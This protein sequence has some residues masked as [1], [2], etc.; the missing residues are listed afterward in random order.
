MDVPGARHRMAR[1]ARRPA[2]G[3]TGRT[4]A[5]WR[6]APAVIA[7]DPVRDVVVVVHV[8]AGA[9][10]GRDDGSLV[11]FLAAPEPSALNGASTTAV[12]HRVVEPLVVIV[13][14]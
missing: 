14:G 6:V 12:G 8:P 13:S 4:G 3:R 10:D 1:A 2:R 11:L 7:R 5:N 9:P